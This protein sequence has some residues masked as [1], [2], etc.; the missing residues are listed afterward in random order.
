MTDRKRSNLHL[1]IADI[2]LISMYL[3]P[4][5]S[6]FTMGVRS[7]E[8]NV[9]LTYC[10]NLAGEV[11]CHIKDNGEIIWQKTCPQEEMMK[12]IE[13]AFRKS[14]YKWKPRHKI[15]ILNQEQMEYFNQPSS[16]DL[17][18]SNFE[19]EDFLKLAVQMARE[20]FCGENRIGDVVKDQPVLGLQK[21]W[22]GMYIVIAAPDRF[23]IR[24]PLRADKGLLGELYMFQALEIYFD[25]LDEQGLLKNLGFDPDSPEG[26][27]ILEG[28]DVSL[29]NI[30][31]ADPLDVE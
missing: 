13:K 22:S 2:P 19:L 23:G 7:L 12:R 27:R 1:T 11:D 5:V 15:I 16:G 30:K 3:S 4:T 6:G 18:T 9:K 21:R 24:F 28:L 20:I 31:N 17:K 25:Y 8:R 26:I 14:V 29:L 10:V